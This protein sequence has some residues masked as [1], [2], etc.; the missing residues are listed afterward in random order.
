MLT[1]A[2]VGMYV[3]N[4]Y[5]DAGWSN[6]SGPTTPSPGPAQPAARNDTFIPDCTDCTG[7]TLAVGT[8]GTTVTRQHEIDEVN[9]WEAARVAAGQWIGPR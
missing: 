4:A 6:N 3:W 1:S 8:G 2:N 5:G 7:I 9:A